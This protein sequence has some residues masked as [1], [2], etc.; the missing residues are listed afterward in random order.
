VGG[1]TQVSTLLKRPVLRITTVT[2]FLQFMN[3]A[4]TDYFIPVFLRDAGYSATLIG[5]TVTLRTTGMTLVRLFIGRI[6]RR[7]G[8]LHL[9]FAALL[10]CVVA[11]GLIPLLPVTPYVLPGSFV[12]GVAFGLA[13]VLTAAVVAG[14]TNPAER[15]LA[16]AMDGTAMYTSRVTSGMVLGALAQGIGLGPAIVAGNAAILIGLVAVMRIYRK[17]TGT[18]QS[19][20]VLRR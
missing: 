17:V 2:T 5:A 16:M 18:Q 19:G 4:T 1:V 3:I 13:P 7:F 9:L 12:A 20:S 8:M 6:T 10:T 14:Q 11:T 15:N